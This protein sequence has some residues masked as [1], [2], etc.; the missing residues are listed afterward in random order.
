ME[1]VSNA[2]KT[3]SKSNVPSGAL[4]RVII[5]A[6]D[7]EDEIE[8]TENDDLQSISIEDNCYVNDRFIGSTVAKKVIINILNDDNTYNLENK[9]IEVKVGFNLNNVEELIS[10]GNYIIEKPNNEEVQSKTSFTGYDYMIKFNK[11]F[12]DNNTYPIALGTYFSNLCSQVGLIAGSTTFVNSDYMVLGNPFTNGETCRE[13]LSAIAQIAGGIAKIG[14][15]NK[16]YIISLSKTSELETI[17]GN[18]YDTFSPNNV[19][20]PINKVILKMQDDVEGEE[21]VRSDTE[22]IEQYG[23]CAITISNNP[24]LNSTEQRELVIDNIFNSIKGITYLPFKVSYYGY[25][26]IDSTDKVKILNVNDTQ[27][28]SY[29]FNHTIKYDGAFSGN[30]ETSALTKTQSIYTDT[31]DIKKWRK[32]TEF[33]VDKINGEIQEVIEQTDE[34]NQKIAEVTHTVNELNQKIR[35]IANITISEESIYA[36]VELDGINQSEPIYVK[37]HPTQEN[38]SYLYPR[39]NLYPSNNLFSTNRKLRFHNTTTDENFDYELPENLLICDDVYDEFVLDYDAQACYVTK[40]VGYNADGTTYELSTPRTNTYPFPSGEDA[41]ELTDGDYEVSLLGY[42]NGYLFVRLMAQNI[43]TTQFATKVEMHSEINQTATSIIE[44]VEENYETKNNAQQKYSEL[45][46]TSSA[47]SLEVGQ[48]LNSSDFTKANIILEIN[49]GQGSAKINAGT[50]DLDAT[51]ILNLIAGNA[52]NLTSKNITIASTNF[53]VDKNGNMTCNNATVNGTINS[54]NGSIGGWTINNQGLSNG[55]VFIKSSG[56]TT[57]YT[58]ADLIIIRNYIM[59]LEG[60]EMS[61][62]M[63][64]HYDFNNDGRVTSADYMTLQNLIGISMN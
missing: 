14:R 22:S 15:D 60:F 52:I 32:N 40:R 2:F 58:V 39:N 25:P 24:I 28:D 34:Q 46:L 6:E 54:S 18:N 33:K 56:A 61:P 48:K 59:G 43:Y 9:E 36:N 37:I 26:Y 63:I 53:N 42:S 20:G 21:S 44:G 51:D 62:S 57:I 35:D 47:I 16:P 7:S 29:I 4:G 1:N 23:E 11:E 55:T 10:Y 64:Q 45:E 5:L 50:I 17:D 38:I 19:F 8:I 30:I 49:N 41:I 3:M 13:V 12:V 27:F 31:R